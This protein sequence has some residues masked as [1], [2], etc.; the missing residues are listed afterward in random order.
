MELH[1]RCLYV[2]VNCSIYLSEILAESN[3]N[4]RVCTSVLLNQWLGICR[5]NCTVIFLYIVLF[6]STVNIIPKP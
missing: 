5:W 4:I 2:A 3:F 6:N 1:E